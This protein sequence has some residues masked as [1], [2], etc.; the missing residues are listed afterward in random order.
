MPPQTISTQFISV[1]NKRG[2]PGGYGII[3]ASP[4]LVVESRA[5]YYDGEAVLEVATG[6]R[7]LEADQDYR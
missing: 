5:T 2:Q 7:H 1:S 6:S 3:D 4:D